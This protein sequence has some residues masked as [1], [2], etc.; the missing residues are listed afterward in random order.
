MKNK[1]QP[2]NHGRFRRSSTPVLQKQLRNC[3]PKAPE[4]V[5]N[6]SFEQLVIENTKIVGP[7]VHI[8]L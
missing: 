5:I 6:S 4:S 1:E 7:I 3:L 8:L 2:T